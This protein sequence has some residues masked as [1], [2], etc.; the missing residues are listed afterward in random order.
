M[1]EVFERYAVVLEV[2]AD[3]R[4]IRTTH[5]H[6]FCVAKKGWT[7]ANELQV[8]DRLVCA[9]TG[10]VVTVESVTDTG[11]WELVYNLR[12]AEYHTYFVGGN[13]W[14]FDVWAHNAYQP[15]FVAGDE[16]PLTE[17]DLAHYWYP[18]APVP[19]HTYPLPA[20]TPG[21]RNIALRVVNEIRSYIGAFSDMSV[22]CVAIVSRGGAREVWVS[23]S[24]D[25]SY[26]Q[27]VRRR[28]IYQSLAAQGID[29]ATTPVYRVINATNGSSPRLN[30]AERHILR[31]IARLRRGKQDVT[32]Q[33]IGSSLRVCE[34]CEAELRR[35]GRS[36]AISVPTALNRHLTSPAGWTERVQQP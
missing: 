31:E 20:P 35:T 17:G 10:K 2:V 21:P 6:P 27:P 3:G 36:S 32:L 34:T 12:V 23:G 25:A 8:G 5:E 24:G 22:T 9:E 4:T 15:L 7:P 30:D 28:A 13:D 16:V 18:F 33:A 1:E 19:G 26:I 29:L 11:E 14:G